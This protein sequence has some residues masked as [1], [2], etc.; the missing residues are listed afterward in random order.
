MDEVTIPIQKNKRN[1]KNNKKDK[2]HIDLL[3]NMLWCES[4][5]NIFTRR[6]YNRLLVNPENWICETSSDHIYD[7]RGKWRFEFKYNRSYIINLKIGGMSKEEPIFTT[8]QKI[9]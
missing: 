4:R 3:L 1:L 5:G 9:G 8:H 6:L 2:I 7:L